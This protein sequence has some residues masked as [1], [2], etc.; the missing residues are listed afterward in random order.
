MKNYQTDY[1]EYLSKYSEN[2]QIHVWIGGSFLN[3]SATNFSDIDISV[4][5][6][7][8]KLKKLIY[9]YGHPVF[10][11]YTGNP[12]GILIVIYE[13]G[14][15]L[16]LEII[17]EIDIS[18]DRYFHFEDIK[19]IEY[20]RNENLCESFAFYNDE[21]YMMSRLFHRS[22]IKYLSGKKTLGI[23]ILNEI[24]LFLNQDLIINEKDYSNTFLKTLD[25]FSSKNYINPKYYNIL[26][27]L[28]AQL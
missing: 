16:D 19:N 20:T 23:N 27:E 13:N 1:I 8:N 2:N 25:V 4:F 14:V 9:D 28:Y 22:I 12:K 3:N 18:S 7:Y 24:L 21:A 5:C 10:I 26:Y 6:S 15:A 11:S 17:K